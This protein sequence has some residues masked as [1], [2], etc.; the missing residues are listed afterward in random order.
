MEGFNLYR[1][2]RDFY[3]RLIPEKSDGLILLSLFD[4]FGE[5]DFKEDEIIRIINITLRD[6]GSVSSRVENERNNN[7]IL[8]LQDYFLWRDSIKKAYRFKPYG[9]E[10]CRRTRKRLE[11]SYSPAKIKRWFDDLYN[12]LQE[13]INQEGGFNRWVEDHFELRHTML[14]EQVEILDQQVNESVKDFKKQLKHTKEKGDIIQTIQGIEMGLEV[15]KQQATEL[16]KAFHTTYDIDDILTQIL[17]EQEASSYLDDIKRVRDFND[18]VRSHLEQVSNRIE[19]I[20]PRIREFI[21]DFNQ[22]DF[23]RKTEQF[24]D[25]LLSY[26]KCTRVEGKKLLELPDGVPLRKI[27]DRQVFPQF[28]IVPLREIGP[29][30][31]VEV[32]KRT[33]DKNKR[34]K[35]V[36]KAKAWKYEKDRVTY[37]AKFAFEEIE[38]NGSLDFSPLFFQILK[39]EQLNLSIAVKTAQRVLKMSLKNKGLSVQIQQEAFKDSSTPN[40]TLWRMKVS[41]I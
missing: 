26:S 5:G 33:I 27:A 40:I 12:R 28:T 34:E 14:G 17:E 20:K 23:D 29:K 38:H 11:D 10:F 24:L 39:E 32:P 3:D 35:L 41:K 25:V 1:E 31:P 36:S 18:H 2:A 16:K 9:I 13:A 4:K 21:Y 37:W 30:Q 8:R 6:L 15:I 22:R 19:K 7:I